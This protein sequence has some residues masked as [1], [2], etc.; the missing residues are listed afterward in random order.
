VIE[1]SSSAQV[2]RIGSARHC[3]QPTYEVHRSGIRPTTQVMAGLSIPRVASAAPAASFL[4]PS[5]EEW[6]GRGLIATKGVREDLFGDPN[7]RD[8]GEPHFR[9]LEPAGRVAAAS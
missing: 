3:S 1:D 4:S 9:E 8:L 5:G 7:I 2:R 6:P